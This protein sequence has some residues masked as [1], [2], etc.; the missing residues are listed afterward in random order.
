MYIF[1]LE[2]VVKQKE[3]IHLTEQKKIEWDN[4]TENLRVQKEF[5]WTEIEA[6]ENS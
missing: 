5:S 6:V 2:K 4:Q 3:N 1:W